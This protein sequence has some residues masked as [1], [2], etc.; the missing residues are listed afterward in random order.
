MADNLTVPGVGIV[1]TDDVGGAHYQRTKPVHGANGT[2]TD[3][4]G[5]DPL[6]VAEPEQ[7]FTNVA[8]LTVSNTSIEAF[9]VSVTPRTCWMVVPP[10]ADTGVRIVFNTVADAVEATGTSMLLPPGFSGQFRT[11]QQIKMI[12]AGSADVSVSRATSVDAA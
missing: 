3:T 5:T 11:K 4:S 9:A 8:D 12:R 10:D 7:T 1:A 2:A 6:P